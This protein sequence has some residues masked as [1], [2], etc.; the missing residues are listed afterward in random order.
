MIHSLESSRLMLLSLCQN[1]CQSF[2]AFCLFGHVCLTWC[3]LLFACGCVAV[4]KRWAVFSLRMLC[5]SFFHLS[6]C[7][8]IC[9]HVLWV[10]VVSVWNSTIFY[11]TVCTLVVSVLLKG[12]QLHLKLIVRLMNCHWEMLLSRLVWDGQMSLE[13]PCVSAPV[14]S[15]T[16]HGPLWSLPR[17]ANGHLIF[18]CRQQTHFWCVLHFLIISVRGCHICK[19]ICLSQINYN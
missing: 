11:L 2:D 14:L 7:F 18:F 9:S 12:I 10:M 17:D 8:R 1:C 3:H 4:C 6:V 13:M 19:C 5:F 15:M 16:C